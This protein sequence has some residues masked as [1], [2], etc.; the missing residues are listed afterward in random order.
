[1]LL[2]SPWFFTQFVLRGGHKHFTQ[3]QQAC[4]ERL[5]AC[6][7]VCVYTQKNYIYILPCIVGA[8][9]PSLVAEPGNSLW[10]LGLTAR[11]M[12]ELGASLCSFS[13]EDCD[14]GEHWRW[15]A[16]GSEMDKMPAKA[17][18]SAHPHTQDIQKGPPHL[19]R[20]SHEPV[21]L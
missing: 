8:W 18:G 2:K 21:H 15:L 14:H 19:H 6:T 10:Q 4:C 17:S 7:Y 9:L 1:M 13:G 12:S 16:T 3:F 11:S 20:F 5:H